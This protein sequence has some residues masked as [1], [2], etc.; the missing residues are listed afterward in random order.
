MGAGFIFE[1]WGVYGTLIVKTSY[2][3]AYFQSFNN[4]KDKIVVLV[5]FKV[6]PWLEKLGQLGEKLRQMDNG[7]FFN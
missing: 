2:K 6:V 5:M 7:A 3:Q 1:F 4:L